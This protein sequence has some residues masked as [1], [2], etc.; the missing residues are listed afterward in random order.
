MNFIEPFTRIQL[1]SL[2]FAVVICS[3]WFVYY[4]HIDV[5]E[6]EPLMGRAVTLILGGVPVPF[7]F[8]LRNILDLLIGP[9]TLGHG[10]FNDLE[11]SLL[12]IGVVEEAVKIVPVLLIV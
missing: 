7:V 8:V 3:T 12:Y 2:I 4:K 10:W 11:Y 1:T 5:F 6:P 9:I